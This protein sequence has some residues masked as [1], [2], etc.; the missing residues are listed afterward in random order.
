[1]AVGQASLL[2]VLPLYILELGDGPAVAALV[3][4]MRGLGSVIVNVPASLAIEKY[5]HRASMAAGNGMMCV[6]ALLMAVSS[7]SWVAAAATLLFGAGMGTWL[8]ARLAFITHLVP[9]H[10]RGAALSGLAGLQRMGLLVGPL[11][12][13]FGVESAGYR[14]VFL[15]IAVTA[16]LTVVLIR[17]FAPASVSPTPGRDDTEAAWE[18]APGADSGE[19][20]PPGLLTLV[21]T[22]LR[23]HRAIFLSAGLFVFSLQLLREQRRLLVVLW[24]TSIGLSAEDI[25]LIV[26]LA[27]AVDMAMFPAAGFVMD[28]WG[29]KPAGVSCIGLLS[30]AMGMLPLT[31]TTMSFA[32]VCA[33]AA[34]GNGLGAGIILTMGADLA[35]ARASSQF[36]GVWRMV[37]DVGALTGPLLTSIVAS[38]V[39]ALGLSSLVGL[40]GGAVLWLFVD[41]TLSREVT[42]PAGSDASS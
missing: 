36:L 15:C 3:F 19:P 32:L 28:H 31:G 20:S 34:V 27:S 23:Q 6:S 11:L 39:I 13:G 26:S 35:P 18:R 9:S 37:G 33:L 41:E 8:L 38:L 25:G 22:I 29:R 1:M 24:G 21:P 17:M 5:G 16:L 7:S 10:Q 2:F 12:G 14:T 42:P 30:V 4:T 40:V